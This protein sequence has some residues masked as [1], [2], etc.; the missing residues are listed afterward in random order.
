MFNVLRE[1]ARFN[2]QGNGAAVRL[3]FSWSCEDSQVA[4]RMRRSK[5]GNALMLSER[6]ES[7]Q[8][9]EFGL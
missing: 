8:Y 9:R 4:A 7:S 1:I 2:W 3:C 6:P 5:D